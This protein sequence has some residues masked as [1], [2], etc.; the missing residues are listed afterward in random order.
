MRIVKSIKY[1]SLLILFIILMGLAITR[2][3]LEYD[4]KNKIYN[5][6]NIPPAKVAIVF[7]AG[8]RRDGSPT[9]VLQDRVA[10]AANLYFQGK[11][12]KILMSGDNRYT[13]YNEPA[14]MQAYAIKLGVP[15]KDIVLDFAGRRTYD[16]CY[17]ALHIFNVEKAIIVT[18]R[19]HL[20]RALFLCK[21][22][23]VESYGVQADLRSYL[24]YSMIIWQIRETIA[25]SGAL[26]DIW[27]SKPLPVLGEPEPIF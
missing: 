22:L 20:P 25:M 26:W 19:F 4:A 11:V 24:K 2:F 3:S 15:E 1:L 16:T 5:L 10:T 27:I 21:M 13:N 14:S 8:I 18:Q 9:A 17:R 23:G 6:V 12:Q 7:G